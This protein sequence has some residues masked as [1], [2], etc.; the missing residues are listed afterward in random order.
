[1]LSLLFFFYWPRIV[2]FWVCVRYINI[3]FE[4]WQY[5]CAGKLNMALKTERWWENVALFL[6]KVT[7]KKATRL[8]RNFFFNSPLIRVFKF[9]LWYPEIDRMPLFFYYVDLLC[10]FLFLFLCSFFQRYFLKHAI[11]IYIQ[12]SSF[13]KTFINAL[14]R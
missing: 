14:P 9:F 12:V 4:R 10:T 8:H 5:F 13:E 7:I 6:L 2:F 11:V 1:M 3:T